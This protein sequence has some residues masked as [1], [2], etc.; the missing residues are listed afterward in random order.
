[1][2]IIYLFEINTSRSG[3]LYHLCTHH[4]PRTKRYMSSFK[5]IHSRCTL[6]FFYTVSCRQ[7]CFSLDIWD[8]TTGVGIAPR[9]ST[10]G[11]DSRYIAGDDHACPWE[12]DAETNDD[13]GLYGDG[14]S[15]WTW[16]QTNWTKIQTSR[17]LP[18]WRHLFSPINPSF[19]TAMRWKG[20]PSPTTSTLEFSSKETHTIHPRQV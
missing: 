8:V 11:L 12:P 15:R 16:T 6:Y 10:Y 9:L 2:H 13:C 17:R 3:Q 20:P 19:A 7:S 5:L 18:I 1:M 14:W 4:L